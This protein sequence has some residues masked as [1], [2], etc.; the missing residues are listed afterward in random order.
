MVQVISM[1]IT[2]TDGNGGTDGGDEN[3]GSGNRDGDD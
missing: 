2:L 1:R 3:G